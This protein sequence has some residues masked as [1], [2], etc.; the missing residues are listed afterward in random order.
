[1]PVNWLDHYTIRTPDLKRSVTFYV[2][3]LGLV[4]GERPS[5][6]FPGAWLYCGERPVVHLVGGE[7]GT[8]PGGGAIDHVAFR[9]SGLHDYTRRLGAEGI[10]F[11]ER[12]VP[13]TTLSQVFLKDPDGV[14]IELNFRDEAPA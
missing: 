5:F 2:D 14:A 7:H 10:P 3:V 1:M 9:A 4:E 11:D 6:D 8:H 12:H 13:G